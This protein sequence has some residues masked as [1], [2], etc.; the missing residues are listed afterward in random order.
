MDL[1]INATSSIS[2]FDSLQGLQTGDADRFTCI[3]PDYKLIIDPRQLRRMSRIMRMGL[4]SAIKT[5]E[6]AN[7]QTPQS[8]ITATG[9]GCLDDT[10]NF[11]VK[12]CDP[13]NR[14]MNPTAFIQSIHN[15]MGGQIAMH[16]KSNCYNNT[17]TQDVLSFEHA[18]LDTIM[19]LEEGSIESVLL[20]GIDEL[21]ELKHELTS[22]LFKAQ[23]ESKGY[24]GQGEGS[25]FFS[26]SGMK[27]Q[28]KLETLI[29]S[30]DVKHADI[31]DYVYNHLASKGKTLILNGK[32][33]GN[34]D[35]AYTLTGQIFGSAPTI[36]YKKYCGDYPT[37]CAFATWLAS[38]ILT[39]DVVFDAIPHPEHVLIYHAY[40][41]RPHTLI[42]LSVC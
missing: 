1:Y 10:G 6:I 11:L 20:G 33:G 22:R 32:C 42:H 24:F 30:Q 19:L 35:E 3:E 2:A 37:S 8:V 26:I 27:S 29:L 25:A 15:T 13:D 34:S 39:Q 12:M 28:V 40:L 31:T 41:D 36:S 9:L 21:T 14:M 7:V 4:A 23:K 17:F 5:L 16:L 18:L 38:E